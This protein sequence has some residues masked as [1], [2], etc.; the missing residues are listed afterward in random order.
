MARYEF[1]TT[2]G[3]ELDP[4]EMHNATWIVTKTFVD[5]ENG[6]PIFTYRVEPHSIDD[7]VVADFEE[8]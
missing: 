5:F 4:Q 2:E 7:F 6:E 8:D 1:E 3:D